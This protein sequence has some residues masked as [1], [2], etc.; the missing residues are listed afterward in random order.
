M[1]IEHISANEMRDA[2]G[3]LKAFDK[4]EHNEV[5][6]DAVARL[7]EV[8]DTDHNGYVDFLELQEGLRR[9]GH[10]QR[11]SG[12]QRGRDVITLDMPVR[13]AQPQGEL[14]NQGTAAVSQACMPCTALFTVQ[15]SM[16]LCQVVCLATICTSPAGEKA[17]CD[18]S[19]KSNGPLS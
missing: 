16:L 7:M 2:L 15:I 12:P 8:L 13:K 14:G 19:D 5:H 1:A 3:H 17:A 10:L 4:L 18:T 9:D 6:G 11:G